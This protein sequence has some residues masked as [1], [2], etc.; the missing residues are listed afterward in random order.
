MKWEYNKFKITGDHPFIRLYRTAGK[1]RF[2]IL[3]NI[4]DWQGD[5]QVRTTLIVAS[6]AVQFVFPFDNNKRRIDVR[7][8]LLPRK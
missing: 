1:S 3:F 5:G 6:H 2:N 4:E 7:W 8:S